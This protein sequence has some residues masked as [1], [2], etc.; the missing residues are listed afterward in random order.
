MASTFMLNPG[1]YGNV[2]QTSGVLQQFISR[3]VV[4]GRVM[5]NSNKQYHVKMKIAGFGACSLYPFAM[6]YMG[7]F[8]EDKPNI[9][10]DTYYEFLNK[11]YG[12]YTIIKHIKLNTHL[13][14]PLTPKMNEDG[15]R[16]VNHDMENA[17]IYTDKV[18]L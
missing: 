13:E 2:Y 12:Y 1:C 18:G 5:T 17:I 10:N 7:G 3:C 6:Y 9:L 11:Q 15:V 8:L 16:A 4:G 14:F